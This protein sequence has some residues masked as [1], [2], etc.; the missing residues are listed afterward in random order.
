MM[1]LVMSSSVAVS[2]RQLGIE[3]HRPARV[4]PRA[5]HDDQAEHR[6]GADQDQ[7]RIAVSSDDPLS[8]DEREQGDEELGQIAQ[9]GL[10][11]ASDR[12]AEAVTDLLGGEEH[13]QA[14][15]QPPRPQ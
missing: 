2:L 11:Q 1:K 14:H 8:G 3:A 15:Q 7:P 10:Q 13:D 9:R 6:Q 12:G 4:R 5:G